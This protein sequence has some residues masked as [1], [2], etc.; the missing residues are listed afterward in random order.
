MED[1]G[2]VH[3]PNV[4]PGNK[5][6]TVGHQYSIVGFLPEQNAENANI[7]WMLP[8]SVKRVATSANGI[9]VAIEQLKEVLLAFNKE[10]T[11]NVGDTAYSNPRFIHA[12]AQHEALVIISRLQSN[13]RFNRKAKSK[14][15]KKTKRRE[16]GHELWYGD[17]F[18]LKTSVLRN[19]VSQK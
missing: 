5:P 15:L 2:I 3:A 17:E 6:I 11:V 9:D 4:V 18:K 14:K 19:C 8:L 12:A 10:L 7:P 1:K 13:R 16:R